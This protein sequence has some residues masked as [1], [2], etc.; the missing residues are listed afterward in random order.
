MRRHDKINEGWRGGQPG[1][2]PE[3]SAS[4]GRPTA[5]RILHTHGI[6]YGSRRCQCPPSPRGAVVV[7]LTRPANIDFVADRRA[8]DLVNLLVSKIQIT[9]WRHS[10]TGMLPIPHASVTPS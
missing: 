7:L 8:A 1:L 3:R 10:E 9:Q 6:T 5:L 4:G 2:L